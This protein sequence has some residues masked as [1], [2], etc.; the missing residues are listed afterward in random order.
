MLL[1]LLS[2]N[3]TGIGSTALHAA[4]T[5]SWGSSGN[6]S[7]GTRSSASHSSRSR[8]SKRSNSGDLASEATRVLPVVRPE[9]DLQPPGLVSGR[10]D[11]SI[12]ILECPNNLVG[13]LPDPQEI[14]L[15]KVKGLAPDVHLLVGGHLDLPVAL[16]LVGVVSGEVG[17]LD[18]NLFSIS[19]DIPSVLAAQSFHLILCE[20]CLL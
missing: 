12:S 14:P 13:H 2:T 6:R 9:L 15:E 17:S 16:G 8:P 11:L 20:K 19:K 7:R 4:L 18:G 3:N 1:S 5:G 10:D